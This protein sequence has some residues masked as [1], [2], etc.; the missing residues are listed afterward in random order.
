MAARTATPMRTTP[1]GIDLKRRDE[2]MV[3]PGELPSITEHADGG[4]TLDL[5]TGWTGRPSTP[6]IVEEATAVAIGR[7]YQTAGPGPNRVEHATIAGIIAG[8]Q[9]VQSAGLHT[10][11]ITHGETVA[12]WRKTLKNADPATADLAARAVVELAGRIET[13]LA[14]PRTD[15][16]ARRWDERRNAR[17]DGWGAAADAPRAH[18]VTADHTPRPHG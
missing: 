6:S 10:M 15:R 4:V 11:A 13:D 7:T 9:L 14:L 5:T 16:E 12:G 3:D 17:T 2:T 1:R 8:H 18:A